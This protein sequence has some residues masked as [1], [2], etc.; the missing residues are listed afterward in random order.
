MQRLLSTREEILVL[1]HAYLSLFCEADK[2]IEIFF[3]NK[4]IPVSRVLSVMQKYTL[5]PGKMIQ[6]CRKIVD[7]IHQKQISPHCVKYSQESLSRLS[8][9]GLIEIDRSGGILILFE[10]LKACVSYYWVYNQSTTPAGSLS[11]SRSTSPIR[12]HTPGRSRTPIKRE[13]T[14]QK[15]RVPIA[16]PSP[17]QLEKHFEDFDEYAEIEE[18]IFKNESCKAA[19]SEKIFVQPTSSETARILQSPNEEKYDPDESIF[20]IDEEIS[21]KGEEMS[22]PKGLFERALEDRFKE[23]LRQKPDSDFSSISMRIQLLD[24]F[25]REI[26]DEIR[27]KYLGRVIEFESLASEIRKVNK[28]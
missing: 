17:M 15:K 8:E 27:N 12:S 22:R 3:S 6:T 28:K 2:A 1:C 26:R 9:Q 21:K 7:F 16:T 19:T 10:Y 14:P 18:E 24:L 25:E 13:K 5:M 11:P 4:K 23:F 20:E